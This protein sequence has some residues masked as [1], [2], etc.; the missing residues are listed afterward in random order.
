MPRPRP[1]SRR[2]LPVA[3][4]PRRARQGRASL[5]FG[6]ERPFL[7]PRQMR[8]VGEARRMIRARPRP[9]G[10]LDAVELGNQPS[11][12]RRRLLDDGVDRG[13][14]AGD[15]LDLSRRLAAGE[16]PVSKLDDILGG[17]PG[18]TTGF[19]DRR[20][21]GQLR[22]IS[23]L[24]VARA[25]RHPGLVVDY[26]EAAVGATI[27]AV[28]LAD[29][30]EGARWAGED[31]PTGELAVTTHELRPA[32]AFVRDEPARDAG[33]AWPPE[34]PHARAR[35]RRPEDLFADRE[36]TRLGVFGQGARMVL[37]EA[38]ERAVNEPPAL[39]GAG[40]GIERIK[41]SEPQDMARID[42]IG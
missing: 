31:K 22:C 42:R 17:K 15:R 25:R 9:V 1:S 33:E 38:I 28:G 7:D 14:I 4:A 41:R 3:A 24:D 32:L 30:F 18:E 16:P 13:A 35:Q 36:E 8:V 12:T 34:G 37:D 39:R 6:H 21:E 23:V 27:D 2:R 40:I 29:Q 20:L 19:G 26:D 5:D 11:Q 10:C